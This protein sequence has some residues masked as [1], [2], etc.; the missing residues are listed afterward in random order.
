MVLL[1]IVYELKVDLWAGLSIDDGREIGK[2]EMIFSFL[3]RLEL[4]MGRVV[5]EID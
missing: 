5:A 3:M 4:I 2:V 1:C